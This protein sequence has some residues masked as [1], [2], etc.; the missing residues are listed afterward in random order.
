MKKNKGFAS[1]LIILAIVFIAGVSAVSY[2]LG[3][4]SAERKEAVDEK[5]ETQKVNSIDNISWKEYKNDELGFSF[6]YPS[7]YEVTAEKFTGENLNYTLYGAI[8]GKNNSFGFSDFDYYKDLRASMSVKDIINT[9]SSGIIFWRSNGSGPYEC[10]DDM[11]CTPYSDEFQY[12]A[13]FVTSKG[14]I[15]SFMAGKHFNDGRETHTLEEIMKL[16]EHKDFFET[17]KTVKI[18]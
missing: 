17:I 14:K 4:H 1:V 10:Y 2:F 15:I 6:R 5:Q 13:R 8:K 12:G 9:E 18:Y 3:K 7:N 11:D 16:P